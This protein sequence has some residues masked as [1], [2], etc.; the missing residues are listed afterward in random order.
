MYWIFS[1]PQV[2][3]REAP[4]EFL[5]DSLG[6]RNPQDHDPHI[7]ERQIGG[8]PSKMATIVLPDSVL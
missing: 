8:T 4:A 3:L 1:G 7:K 6:Y 2:V 5:S